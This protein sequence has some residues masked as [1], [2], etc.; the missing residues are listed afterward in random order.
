MLVVLNHKMNFRKEQARQYAEQLNQIAHPNLEVVV[1]PSLPYLSYFEGTN[2]R[3]GSQNVSSYLMGSHTGEVSAEQLKSMNVSYCLIGH[4]ERRR[5]QKETEEELREKIRQ[6]LAEQM[7]PILCIGET[8]QEKAS[9]Q[10]EV[11]LQRQLE[12]TLSGLSAEEVEKIIIAYEPIWAIGTGTTPSVL[13][14]RQAI[15]IIQDH[16]LKN[17]A[18][19]PRILY[20]GSIDQTNFKRFFEIPDLDGIL[21][22]GYS[23]NLKSLK[24]LLEYQK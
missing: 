2:Y 15:K 24:E 19:K 6:T 21:I 7:I 23:L 13:E 18:K 22:G 9:H 14:I 3:L 1:C 8:D 17:S 10:T 12:E 4:S 11:V 20:G 16:I 5:D